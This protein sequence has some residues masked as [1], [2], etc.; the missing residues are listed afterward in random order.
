MAAT[1]SLRIDLD[2]AGKLSLVL[3]SADALPGGPTAKV[4]LP[5]N[6]DK[7][8]PE[9]KRREGE[10][11]A[12]YEARLLKHIPTQIDCPPELVDGLRLTL[13]KIVEYAAEVGA[14]Y[15]QRAAAVHAL[16]AA[17]Q[18]PG[19]VTKKLRINHKGP[20]AKGAAKPKKE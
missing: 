10:T 11:D 17:D 3:T 14:H 16:D 20:S 19:D 9:L 4:A 1:H 12:A 6:F 5:L 13:A 18:V 7:A 15:A 2:A 8:A